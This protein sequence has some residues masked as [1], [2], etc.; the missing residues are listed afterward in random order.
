MECRCTKAQGQPNDADGVLHC[1]GCGLPIP[2]DQLEYW[3]ERRAYKPEWH[4][5]LPQ[6]YTTLSYPHRGGLVSSKLR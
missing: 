3:A 5:S 6:F 2:K 4:R 1:A